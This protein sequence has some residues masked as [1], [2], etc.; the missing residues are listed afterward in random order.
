VTNRITAF[1]NQ[2]VSTHIALREHL[3]RLRDGSVTGTDLQTHCLTFC[4]VL[5]GHHE[6]EDG[7]GFPVLAKQYPELAPVLTELSNDH[8]LVAAALTRLTALSMMDSETARREL[9]TVAALLETHF[10]Y[11]ERKLVA[12]LNALRP[13]EDDATTV[14][15]AVTID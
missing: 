5:T 4:A 1:G 10:T 7:G 15:R 9:D 6:A 14:L 2:L 3:D 8:Q 12:A 11:E 13:N